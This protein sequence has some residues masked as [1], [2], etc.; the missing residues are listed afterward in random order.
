MLSLILPF[1]LFS[2]VAVADDSSEDEFGFI[3]EGE[4]NRAKLE[5]DRAPNAN[6][7]LEEEEE[8]QM[9]V[10][11]AETETH[12]EADVDEIED[13]STTGTSAAIF[14]SDDPEEDMEGFGPDMT[15]KQ[16]LGDHFPLT[17][18]RSPLGDLVAELPVLVARNSDDL[19][20][21]LWVVADI[22]TDGVKVSESRHFVSAQSAGELSPTYVW[23]KTT[24]PAGGP[25]GVVEARV[26]AA[27]PGKK[28]SPLFTRRANYSL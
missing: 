14:E 5:A 4:K 28:E 10:H 13:F 6:I 18:S 7:F 12:S 25:A 8:E 20:G 26:F 24:I 27:P 9:W 3:E 15:G 16:P 23:I 19:Q 1:V 22:Y 21:D 17:V 2:P 11:N